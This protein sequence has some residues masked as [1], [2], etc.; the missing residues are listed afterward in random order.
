MRLKSFPHP[1]VVWG[2]TRD[3]LVRKVMLASSSRFQS[4]NHPLK[5]ELERE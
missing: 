4:V 1:L 3:L 2:I 5:I